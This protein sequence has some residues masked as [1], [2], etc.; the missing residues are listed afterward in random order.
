MRIPVAQLICRLLFADGQ[1]EERQVGFSL[2]LFVSNAGHGQ[3][4]VVGRNSG[5]VGT[6]IQSKD[7]PARLNFEDAQREPQAG[8]RHEPFS[9]GRE[10]AVERAVRAYYRGRLRVNRQLP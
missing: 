5:T 9:V 7:F 10:T 1:V 6:T 8:A 4:L 3:R 2:A